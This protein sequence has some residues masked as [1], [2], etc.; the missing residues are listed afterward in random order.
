MKRSGIA[1]S[2]RP[3]AQHQASVRLAVGAVEL[4][5]GTHHVG[6]LAR[7]PVED[8]AADARA[9]PAGAGPSSHVGE[10][11]RSALAEDGSSKRSP[12][13]FARRLAARPSA[14]R[15]RAHWPSRRPIS[16]AA[17]RRATR[18][19]ASSRAYSPHSSRSTGE[20]LSR[21]RLAKRLRRYG[22]SGLEARQVEEAE[23]PA[24]V[25]AARPSGP[26]SQR[27][28][29][30]VPHAE[31]AAG[32]FQHGGDKRAGASSSS[33][34]SQGD[35]PGGR[36]ASAVERA[37]RLLECPD[38]HVRKPGRTVV[39]STPMTFSL[40]RPASSSCSAW[41][42]PVVGHVGGR[43]RNEQHAGSDS[44]P[45][46]GSSPPST[47]ALGGRCTTG[48]AMRSA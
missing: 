4:R 6:A 43:P 25:D 15:R 36:P 38:H 24:A 35:P 42:P 26:S 41:V 8:V 47:H 16:R 13:A 18:L 33:R 22:R 45:A 19:A 21:T 17:R 31:V 10:G 40:M 44:A 11:A 28:Q 32:I 2:S 9:R 48:P 12:S 7:D 20:R 37:E 27:M 3:N 14:R 39:P 1:I 5:V 29:V 46:S 34:A 23:R 30:Q